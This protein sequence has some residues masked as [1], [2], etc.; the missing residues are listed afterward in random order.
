MQRIGHNQFVW[1]KG[2]ILKTI[3]S[4]ILLKTE[5]PIPV[6]SRYWGLPKD[7]VKTLDKMLRVKWFII[8]MRNLRTFFLF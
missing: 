3:N 2:D 4:D 8:I 5:P 6:S 1:G 7:V